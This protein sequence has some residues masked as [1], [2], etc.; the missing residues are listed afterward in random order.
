[1]CT[2]ETCTYLDN[3]QAE[4]KTVKI[5]SSK[6]TVWSYHTNTK[7]FS[8]CEVFPLHE[9]C[10]YLEFFWSVF[11][12]I[13]TEYGEILSMFVFSPNA[14]KCGQ[15]KFQIRTLFTQCLCL[16]KLSLFG[17]FIHH[18]PFKLIFFKQFNKL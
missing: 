3:S 17:I 7:T 1:M 6:K 18:V 16:K 13:R 10:L 2:K 15:E 12:R 9:K 11:S 4:I 5:L 14:G 8:L